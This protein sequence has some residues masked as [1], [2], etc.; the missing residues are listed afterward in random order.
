MS[1][2][3]CGNDPRLRL[4]PGDRQAIAEFRAY[5]AQRAAGRRAADGHHE[6]PPTEEDNDV[7]C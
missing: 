3:R 7:H 2:P 5:L 1:G 6:P 4:T